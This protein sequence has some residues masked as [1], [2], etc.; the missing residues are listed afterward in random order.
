MSHTDYRTLID[1]GRKAGL[2]TSEMYRAIA[3]RR[4]GE[5][6]MGVGQADCN[7]FVSTYNQAGQ[8]VYHP[9]GGY[10]RP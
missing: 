5:A 6:E 7:G 2:G 8:R 4:P 1:R 10:R 9:V 3:A